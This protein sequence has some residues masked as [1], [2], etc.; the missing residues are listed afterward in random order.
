MVMFTFS[1]FDRKYPF[2]ANFVQQI[3]FVS[4]SWNLLSRLIWIWK[5]IHMLAGMKFFY[6]A[7]KC[8]FYRPEHNA[9]GIHQHAEFWRSWNAEMKYNTSHQ[10]CD[11]FFV[12]NSRKQGKWA[13]FYI[14]VTITLWA[15]MITRQ[16]IPFYF[17]IL[18]PSKFSSLCI[19][20][21]LICYIHW[22]TTYFVL[23]LIPNLP[24]PYGP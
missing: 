18:R 7:G 19:I 4:L 12:T 9:K 2:R 21:V 10:N 13:I 5:R 1:I 15:N 16:M 11:W 22:Y 24:W 3:K 6:L 23:N 8:V 20:Y 17:Y 14:V